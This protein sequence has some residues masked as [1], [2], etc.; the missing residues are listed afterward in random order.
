MSPLG[1]RQPIRLGVL[2]SGRGSNLQAIIDAIESG[3]LN[4]R[5][6]VVVC[7]HRRAQA[8]ER[9]TRHGIPTRVVLSRDYGSRSDQEAAILT[10]LREHEVDLLVCAGFDRILGPSLQTAYAGRALNIHPSLLP[11]F[12][13]GLHAQA[14]ALAYG[15]KVTGCTVHLV[16]DDLDAGPIVVQRTVP[17]LEDDTEETLSARILAQEHEAFPEAIALFAAGRVCIEGRHARIAAAED[18]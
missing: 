13:G 1:N 3:R 10:C 17:V 12:G 4:A 16:T 18:F 2:A 9:A 15:V 6:Q 5:V 14:D 8:L 11:S 7:N